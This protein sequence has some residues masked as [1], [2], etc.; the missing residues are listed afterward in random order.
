MFMVQESTDDFAESLED[1]LTY[2]V[3]AV[4]DDGDATFW[5]LKL[6]GS[7]VVVV[8][9]EFEDSVMKMAN[10]SPWI[11][12]VG[13]HVIEGYY[14]DDAEGR[15]G[16]YT[17][18]DSNKV[19][20]PTHM[21]PV[22]RAGAQKWYFLRLFTILERAGRFKRCKRPFSNQTKYKGYK[23]CLYSHSQHYILCLAHTRSLRGSPLST[24][25]EA[26]VRWPRARC[27]S[28]WHLTPIHIK[29]CRC[30][31]LFTCFQ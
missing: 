20:V 19:S 14:Y 10:G 26:P 23:W 6:A 16:C 12:R 25:L 9:E 28:A 2:A 24:A 21:R 27:C 18:L 13:D 3:H 17:L 11:H 8:D 29:V 30:G 22:A 15:P 5:L 1:G 4:D 31:P 7:D